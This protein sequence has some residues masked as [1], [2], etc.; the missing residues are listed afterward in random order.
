M[1]P[2]D[3]QI[4]Q[5]DYLLWQN[6]SLRHFHLSQFAK[7]YSIGNRPK[8]DNQLTIEFLCPANDTIVSQGVSLDLLFAGIENQIVTFEFDEW[9]YLE[10]SP[11]VDIAIFWLPQSAI[12]QGETI[13]DSRRIELVLDAI[14]LRVR[15]GASVYI[16]LPEPGSYSSSQESDLE[17]FRRNHIQAINDLF[18]QAK[19][20]SLIPFE[21]WVPRMD[22]KGWSDSR[23]WEIARLPGQVDFLPQISKIVGAI[24]ANDLGYGIKAIAFDLDGTIWDGI[25][26]DLGVKGIELNRNGKGRSHIA[27]QRFLYDQHQRGIFLGIVSK[28]DEIHAREVFTVRSEMIL[29]SEMVSFWG[30]NWHEKSTNIERMAQKLNIDANTIVFLDDSKFEIF[31]VDQ[32]FPKMNK[33]LINHSKPSLIMELYQ[34]EL[35][36]KTRNVSAAKP[37]LQNIEILEG[38]SNQSDYKLS[39]FNLP[40]E[41]SEMDRTVSLINKTNQF[42]L[43]KNRTSRIKIQELSSSNS[44]FARN[45]EVFENDVSM[46]ILSTVLVENIEGEC[47]I[48]EW[49]LSCRAF[50]RGIEWFILLELAKWATNAGVGLISAEINPTE[51]TKYME[52]FFEELREMR[53]WDDERHLVVDNILRS[54]TLTEKALKYVRIN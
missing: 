27:L 20:V 15:A 6:E 46:G 44:N 13:S 39:V 40:I 54:D 4:D 26:G 45:F 11:K 1:N 42:N 53:I 21:T 51:R 33:I 23:I 43:T 52:N 19:N 34:S 17:N 48:I 22:L 14:S 18:A 5:S 49:V 7:K 9:L 12:T 47:R 28:N 30:V 38:L 37:L 50:S 10:S 36:L 25:L 29:K 32:K 16:L 2:N 8:T 3:L 41:D 24:I 31:E 35:F